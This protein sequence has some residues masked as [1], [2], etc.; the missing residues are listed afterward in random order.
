MNRIKQLRK[1]K[2]LTLQQIADD[3]TALLSPESGRVISK[4]T[5]SRWENEKNSPNSEMWGLLADYFNVSVNYLKGAWSEK[6]V[7]ELMSSSLL[8]NYERL[9][10]MDREFKETWPGLDFFN[11]INID[12][13]FPGLYSKYEQEILNSC[14][15]SLAF[16][17]LSFIFKKGFYENEYSKD[18]IKQ[19]ELEKK[20]SPLKIDKELEGHVFLSFSSYPQA[21]GREYVKQFMGIFKANTIEG[22]SIAMNAFKDRFANVHGRNYVFE[23][24]TVRA[25]MREQTSKR[26]MSLA[27][28]D[29]LNIAVNEFKNEAKF[30]YFKKVNTDI[31]ALN[32]KCNTLQG[33]NKVLQEENKRLK[34]KLNLK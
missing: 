26:I 4:S 20:N 17:L 27:L 18:H 28:V 1:E 34:E 23:S 13:T 15:M 22:R 30:R 25:L 19:I 33:Q 8:E 31:N 16:S 21:K 7:L 9:F 3:L 29:A 11:E 5:I 10:E 2:G 6:E 14:Y 32:E 12:V 24:A